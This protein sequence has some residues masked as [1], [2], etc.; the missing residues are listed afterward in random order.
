MNADPLGAGQDAETV[1][2]SSDFPDPRPHFYSLITAIVGTRILALI[3]DVL[4]SDAG[5]RTEGGAGTRKEAGR[6][7]RRGVCW[8]R[9]GQTAPIGAL[10]QPHPRTGTDY[11][12]FDV[13]EKLDE[14]PSR[15]DRRG[16]KLH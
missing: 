1:R 10:R 7:R 3:L 16:F 9:F 4:R 14:T 15:M 5:V 8:R 12:P 11:T 2:D 6:G 13:M